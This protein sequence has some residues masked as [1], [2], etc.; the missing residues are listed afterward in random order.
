MMVPYVQN[1]T[2]WIEYYNPKT[3][4]AASDTPS[5]IGLAHGKSS[6]LAQE[7]S[8]NVQ[9]VEAKGPIPAAPSIGSST[10]L[11][12]I[13]TSQS[14]IQQAAL[15]AKREEIVKDESKGILEKTK[16]VMKAKKK[17]PVTHKGKNSVKKGPGKSKQAQKALFR[18]TLLGSPADIFKSRTS[19]KK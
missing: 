10:A 17:N 18:K 4:S 14:V 8:M 19:K 9:P 2:K 15:D 12:T 6:G 11:R 16:R 13:S 1:V 5:I 3:V 7:G